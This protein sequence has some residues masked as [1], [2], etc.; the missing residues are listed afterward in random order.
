VLDHDEASVNLFL[1][2]RR[3]NVRREDLVDS[4]NRR[5]VERDDLIRHLL[6]VKFQKAISDN[7]YA[8]SAS[9]TTFQVH[10]F[11]PALK[12][13]D[14]ASSRLLIA[15]EVGLGKTI[16]AGIIFQELSARQMLPLERVL[17]A[18]P[19]GLKEKW[20]D[21]M[22]RRFGEDFNV[23]NASGFLH[24]LERFES[25][26]GRQFRLIV[27]I[28]TIRAQ[29][30][31]ERLTSLLASHGL[32]LD[33]VIIDEAHHL[34]NPDTQTHD[35]GEVLGQAA[36]A[37]LMLTATPV[38]LGNDDL[39]HLLTVLDPG[40]FPDLATFEQTIAPNS[41]VNRI[42]H[43][44]RSKQFEEA[45][46][47]LGLLEAA[48]ATGHFT[49][50]PFFTRVGTFLAQPT[51]DAGDLVQAIRDTKE[52]NTLSG[53]VTRTRKRDV[54]QAAVRRAQPIMVQLTPD[55]KAYYEGV[56]RYA[57]SLTRRPGGGPSFG[58][59]M[60]ERQAASCIPASVAYLS[61]LV[62]ATSNNG[63]SN[64]VEGWLTDAEEVPESASPTTL[65]GLVELGQRCKDSKGEL[66]VTAVQAALAEKADRKILVFSFFKRTL[67]HLADVLSGAGI[68]TLLISGDVSPPERGERIQRFRE[69]ITQVLLSS[70]VGSEGLDFQF[71][72]TLINYDLPWNP[73]RVEQRIGRLD[74]YGQVSDSITIV[75]LVLAKTI[76]ERILFR[77]YE[78]INIFTESIGDLEP[79]L[80]DI[81]SELEREVFSR[82]LT[83]LEQDARAHAFGL[84]IEN[85]RKEL[86]GFTHRVDEFLGTD[87]LVEQLETRKQRGLTVTADDVALAVATVAK[88]HASA[89]TRV[90]NR[91]SVWRLRRSPALADA[92]EKYRNQK[93]LSW[94]SEHATLAA[95]LRAD[96]VFVIFDGEMANR[97]QNVPF[98][99]AGHPLA[100]M[101][102]DEAQR[103]L[104]AGG[105]QLV[106][107][108]SLDVGEPGIDRAFLFIFRFSHTA[109]T[110]G[111]RLFPVAI[112]GDMVLPTE[113]AWYCWAGCMN[114]RTQGCPTRV[115]RPSTQLPPRRAGPLTPNE[116]RCTRNL[117][118]ATKR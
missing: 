30:I 3:V 24:Q 42:E 9:R 63:D 89:L 107:R 79:I 17:I 34:R 84:A 25:G 108:F 53:V 46:Q 13:F 100:R 95:R 62:E 49:G 21:E 90:E 1:D 31:R 23:V 32:T 65:A 2:S 52:L 117:G 98:V 4:P 18:C 57:R 5:V 68:P 36:E 67:A 22:S 85:K 70:E 80:G 54:G 71:C 7:L 58:A 16:E 50:S 12:F 109:A 47:Q 69:G 110:A 43:F 97:H 20:R 35:A 64:E 27:P 82:E 28:E 44:L 48:D 78:R 112:S 38:Q 51:E 81:V 104:E 6:A 93:R 101:A 37:M 94:T 72:D 116:I 10:Q 60:R 41:F 45:S 115:G 14:G 96:D 73:M 118:S 92:L 88:Q 33:L 19:S 91:E 83:P 39:F 40:L 106:Y 55:E 102:I 61:S 29:N 56:S 8:L 103:E 105:G 99:G 77:L 76:E 11:I 114:R 87:D 86:E 74:R 26:S 111:A 66:F 15:D 59:I 75:S 113:T